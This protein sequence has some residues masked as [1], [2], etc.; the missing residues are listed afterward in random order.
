MLFVN[1]S[2]VLE[3]FYEIS[4]AFPGVL[5]CERNKEKAK[6]LLSQVASLRNGD[7]V[8]VEELSMLANDTCIDTATVDRDG[9]HPVALTPHGLVLEIGVPCIS[10]TPLSCN[11]G[12]NLGCVERGEDATGEA[13]TETLAVIDY[14]APTVIAAC[15]P[16]RDTGPVSSTTHLDLAR[17]ESEVASLRARGTRP[18]R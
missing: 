17:S 9:H 2:E 18:A 4:V 5:F 11:M 10:R 16:A 13:W 1:Y 3:G 6:W 15:G 7:A 8:L 12:K 14:H